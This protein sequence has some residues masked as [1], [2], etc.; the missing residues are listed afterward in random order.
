MQIIPLSQIPAQ[1]FNVVLDGQYCT[2]SLYWRQERLYLDL[3]VGTTGI[4]QAAVCQ[5]RAE[6]LQS[7]SPNFHGAL[8]FVDVEGDRP[9]HWEGLYTGSFGRWILVYAE[10]GE[11]LPPNW[12]H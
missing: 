5:N 10:A 2:I 7:K 12:R 6:V 8:H 4:C 9:P 11:V 1:T 3:T